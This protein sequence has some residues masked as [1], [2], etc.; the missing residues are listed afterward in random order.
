MLL[1]ATGFLDD[2][3]N[4]LWIGDEV[5]LYYYVVSARTGE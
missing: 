5:S 2:S 3:K 1:L 4:S